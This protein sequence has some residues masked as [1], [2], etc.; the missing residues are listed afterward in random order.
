MKVT[1]ICRIINSVNQEINSL[2]QIQIHTPIYLISGMLF[3]E[4]TM[5]QIYRKEF[6]HGSYSVYGEYGINGDLI[7]I[8]MVLML[9]NS[10]VMTNMNIISLSTKMM[11]KNSF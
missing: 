7:L 11:S 5:E 6:P 1:R 9:S 4:K 2:F 3:M 10:G 8:I